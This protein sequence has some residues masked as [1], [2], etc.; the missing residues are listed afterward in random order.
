VTSGVT[1][2]G[3]SFS[4]GAQSVASFGA[5]AGPVGV[6]VA[7]IAVAAAGAAIAVAGLAAACWELAGAALAV[8]QRRAALLATFDAFTEGGGKKAL[9]ALAQLA[10]RLPYSTGQVNAW[11]KSLAAAGIT[12]P[13]ALQKGVLAVASATALLGE[14]GGAA[15][16]SLISK[17]AGLAQVGAQVK[18][19]PKLLRGMREAGI[20]VKDL[21]AQLGT[22]PDKL[23]A[24]GV[25]AERM[26]QAVQDA[27]IKKGRGP[28]EELGFGWDA[29]KTKISEGIGIDALVKDLAPAI[30][31]FMAELRSFAEE[32]FKGSIA[33]NVAKG[34]VT[35]VMTTLFQL[36]TRALTEV[37]VGFLLLENYALR[38]AIAIAPAVLWLR[39]MWV[40]HDGASK[41]L[42]VVKGIGV[43]LGLVAVVAAVAFLPLAIIATVVIGGLVAI[44]TAI[45]FVIENIGAAKDAVVGWASSAYNAATKFVGGLVNGIRNGI[46]DVV[47]AA[48]E[49]ASGAIDAVKGVLDINS[50]SRVMLDVGANTA[51][52]MALGVDSGAGEVESASRGLG[53]AAATG[54]GAAPRRAT[55]G[56]GSVHVPIRIEIHGNVDRD[57]FSLLEEQLA[58]VVERVV[59]RSGLLEPEPEGA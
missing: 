46:V 59:G 37:H 58:E 9:G 35:S 14:E 12:G 33:A 18:L 26:G 41:L 43:A 6:A 49:L 34:A 7:V 21:A 27:L 19:D 52:G 47:N 36:A 31:P 8:A 16:T 17:L 48:K 13:A 42:L 24:V 10:E 25:S 50:P 53:I 40:E 55:A 28:L 15:A 54:A 57:V 1:S 2:L 39:K 32:F 29:I 5:T 30:R 51:R 44:G 3:S 38:A 11:G 22:T 20:S 4:S 23:H 45:A 56:R